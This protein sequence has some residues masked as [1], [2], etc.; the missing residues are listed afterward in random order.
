MNNSHGCFFH[1]THRKMAMGTERNELLV[2]ELYLLEQPQVGGEV[3][4]N[5]SRGSG[6]GHLAS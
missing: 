3:L 6:G 2:R 5:E 4:R 1:E